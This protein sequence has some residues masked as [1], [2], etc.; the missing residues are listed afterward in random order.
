MPTQRSRVTVALAASLLLGTWLAGVA[1]GQAAAVEP[2]PSASAARAPV[3]YPAVVHSFVPTRT[4][5]GRSL[6][7]WRAVGGE[8]RALGGEYIGTLRQ[9]GSGWLMLDQSYQDVAFTAE[10][11]CSGECR[12]G[13]LFRGEVTGDRTTG[14]LFS[15]ADGERGVTRVTLD[16]EGRIVDRQSATPARAPAAAPAT[17]SAPV[18]AGLGD[19]TPAQLGRPRPAVT[20]SSDGGWNHLEIYLNAS[21]IRAMLNGGGVAG[22]NISAAGVRYGRIALQV[23]GAPGAEVRFRAVGIKDLAEK[24]AQPVDVTSPRFQKRQL[25]SVFYGEAV[26]AADVNL[27]GNMDVIAGPFVYLGPDFLKRREIYLPQPF[28]VAS[29]P[30]ALQESVADVTGDG[31]PDVVRVGLPRTA[32]VLYVNPGKEVRLWE[33]HEIIPSVDSEIA[34]LD[35]LDGDGKPEFF[36]GDGGYI[37]YAKPDPADPTRP[38]TFVPVTEKGPWGAYFA[39]GLGTG[40][41]NG[42]GRKDVIQAYGWWEQPAT[43]T[44]APWTYHPEAFGRWGPQQG[45]AGGARPFVYDVNGDGLNDVVTSLEAHGW[46]LAWF[47]QKKDA[48]GAISFQ[49]HMIMDDFSAP[50]DGVAFSIL[51]AVALADIDGDGLQDIVTGKRW[52]GSFGENPNDPDFWGP[53]VLYWFRLVREGGQVRYVPELINNNSGVGTQ[54]AAVDLN[55]DGRP[56]VLSTTRRGTFVFLSTSGGARP[57]N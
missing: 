48:S 51:H 24:D 47:E 28:N 15:L 44:D 35:D 31:F 8:W 18:Q 41:I 2:P 33:R 45:N 4:F 43:R 36:Y 21:T 5:D 17:T 26:T 30:D 56:D 14:V 29:Y 11:R 13:V 16:A 46:G 49:R 12:A 37:G 22:G 57:T 53:A 54:I 23:A 1:Q 7:G 25:E 20:L 34:Y 52:W 42:D 3:I 39:Y 40:D 38:W 19:F 50:N 6:A 27:D 10:F 55:R 9:G 32:A